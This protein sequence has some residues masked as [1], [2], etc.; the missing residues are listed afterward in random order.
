MQHALE[1]AKAEPDVYRVLGEALGTSVPH[2]EVEMLVADSSRAHFHQALTT[3]PAP[4]PATEPRSGCGVVS[5]LD[6]PATLRGHTLL[7]P[8]SSV[9]DA[10]PHLKDRPSGACSAVCVAVSLAGKTVG[11]LHATGPDGVAAPDGDVRY[12]EIASRRAA[13]RI[14]MLRAFE[15]SEAQARSDP[16]T[17]LWNRRSLENRVHELHHEGIPYALAYGD[18]DHFKTLNDEQGH[19]AGDQALRLFSR[20]LRDSIRPNDLAG[21]YGGEEFVIVMPDCSVQAATAVLDRLRERLALTLATGRIGA[22][23]VSFGLASSADNDTFDEVIAAA[24]R[25]LFSAKT[26]GRDRIVSSVPVHD[27]IWPE[28][29][30]VAAADVNARSRSPGSRCRSPAS[31]RGLGPHEIVDW[32]AWRPARRPVRPAHEQAPH[33]GAVR[34]ERLQQV[35]HAGIV[36]PSLTGQ[37]VPDV[38]REVPVADRDRVGVGNREVHDVRGRP[39]SDT[40][41]REQPAL[42]RI[43][44]GSGRSVQPGRVLSDRLQCR[45]SATLHAEAAPVPVGQGDQRVRSRRQDK[46]EIARRRRAEPSDQSVPRPAGLESGNPLFDCGRQREVVDR[47]Q[48]HHP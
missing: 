32:S 12:L 35:E 39:H 27:L 30:S 21:R 26:E 13:E 46:A 33:T 8:T 29:G 23:T 4:G 19:E 2:L 34:S 31:T 17:G 18:L 43:S 24:D 7:F 5:P 48:A 38:A 22:F 6:C 45:R 16:L 40:G 15:R 41:C 28:P 3:A 37:R 44:S 36:G 42:Q 9:L 20:V 25:A 14:A 11:V 10:C 47:A 1:M